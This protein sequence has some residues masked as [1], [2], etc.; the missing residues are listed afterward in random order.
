MDDFMVHTEPIWSLIPSRQLIL[1]QSESLSPRRQGQLF[2]PS[3]SYFFRFSRNPFPR[4][5]V[6]RA[7]APSGKKQKAKMNANEPARGGNCA[8]LKLSRRQPGQHEAEVAN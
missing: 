5:Y 6:R 3:R 7:I 2:R 4:S 8:S 1:S